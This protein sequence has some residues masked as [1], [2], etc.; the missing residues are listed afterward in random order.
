MRSVW[1]RSERA[2]PVS[3]LSI[4]PPPNGF[5]PSPDPIVSPDGRYVAFK[6]EDASHTSLLWIK[7]LS[8]P[9][10]RPL[11]GTDG[12]VTTES[13]FWSPDSRSLGFFAHGQ[14]KRVD[15]DGGAPQVLAPAAE[16]RGG[17][18]SPSGIIIFD[19]GDG[20]LHPVSPSG[21]ASTLVPGTAPG[22]RRLFPH[23]LPDGRHYLFTSRNVNGL[24][25]G[26]YVASLDSPEVRRVSDAWSK[27]VYASG[28]LIFGR[29][30]ALFAQPFDS[31]RLEATGEPRHLAD[32]LGVGCCT[33]L[34]FQFSAS[35]RV[36]SFWSGSENFA[37]AAHV[38]RPRRQ[39]SAGC[40][41]A[42]K[43]HR[44]RSFPGRSARGAGTGRPENDQLR[45]LDAG[46]G[47]WQSG[48]AADGRRKR[49][50]AGVVLRRDAVARHVSRARTRRNAVAWRRTQYTRGRP[51]IDV[52]ERLVRRRSV[53]GLP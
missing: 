42:G 30:G 22:Q 49:H 9:V 25:Q 38:A 13:P 21:G 10:A 26:I 15:I 31:V 17:T 24:G 33:P 6:A 43:H 4:L 50:V 1:P 23:S 12:I 3:W 47:Q 36:L 41:R 52:A 27:A 35:V 53:S 39:T 29:Q 20:L 37:G 11:F 48:R 7:D 14:L 32:G 5:D 34:S 16:S 28:H 40:R 2:E 46:S 45:S 44:S 18:W 19:D 8:G 51:N